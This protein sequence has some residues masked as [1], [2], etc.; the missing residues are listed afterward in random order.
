MSP[1]TSFGSKAMTLPM[2]LSWLAA[3][4]TIFL[5]FDCMASPPLPPSPPPYP[6]HDTAALVALMM[7][8]GSPPWLTSQWNVSTNPC[9]SWAGVRCLSPYPPYSLYNTSGSG[10]LSLDFSAAQPPFTGSPFPPISIW[11]MFFNMKSLDC[12][13]QGLQGPASGLGDWSGVL[14][15]LDILKL[16]GN[17][18]SGSLAMPP[19]PQGLIQVDISNNALTGSLPKL[20]L[21][22]AAA[23][24]Q[25]QIGGNA[26][27]TGSIPTSYSSL[28]ALSY[29]N[30]SGNS[31]LSGL[32]PAAWSSLT[33]MSKLDLSDCGF[34]S[35]ALGSSIKLLVCSLI[36][37]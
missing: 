34:S 7:A 21:T 27:I 23:L 9:T 2:M 11:E 31:G 30:M 29:L 6:Y 14:T 37:V 16:G 12:T 13:G 22:N 10:I 17:S 4:M 36:A 32:L 28:T 5:N 15:S 18:L 26:N 33:Q 19:W 25:L 1:K 35:G 24:Q 8:L 20:S 3:F